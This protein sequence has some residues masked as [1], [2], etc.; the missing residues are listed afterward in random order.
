M[1]S[2]SYTETAVIQWVVILSA[3]SNICHGSIALIGKINKNM[4]YTDDTVKSIHEL[5]FFY[6]KR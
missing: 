5:L 2:Y 6:V 1:E 4:I 3:K